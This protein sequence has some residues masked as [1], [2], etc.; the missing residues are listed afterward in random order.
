MWSYTIIIIVGV[1]DNIFLARRY[2]IMRHVWS[3]WKTF[4]GA[5]AS[6]RKTQRRGHKEVL[7]GAACHGCG[8]DQHFEI[9][10]PKERWWPMFWWNVTWV[11][12]LYF[13]GGKPNGVLILIIIDH[14]FASLNVLWMFFWFMFI[15]NWASLLWPT[16]LLKLAGMWPSCRN[17][18]SILKFFVF[19]SPP[20]DDLATQTR[21]ICIIRE[22]WFPQ[23]FHPRIPRLSSQPFFILLPSRGQCEQSA[24]AFAPGFRFYLGAADRF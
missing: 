4:A 23:I 22:I 12:F 3:S 9:Q 1:A 14:M 21:I 15:S 17:L 8:T 18:A 13:L 16:G 10:K 20:L 6:L 19:Q 5:R 2:I 24:M 7:P 11:E